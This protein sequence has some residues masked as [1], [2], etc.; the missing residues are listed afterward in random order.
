MLNLK[1]SEKFIRKADF[2]IGA[3]GAYSKVRLAM[4]QMPLFQYSQEYIEHGY[5]ELSIPSKLGDKMIPNHLHIWPR[6]EFMMIAL[7][8]RDMSWTVTLFM[9]FVRFEILDDKEKVMRFFKEM[10]PDAVELIGENEIA[11]TFL[12]TK[13]SHLVSIRCSSYHA[14]S[15][16]LIIGDAAHAMVPFFGQGMNS[17]FEDCSILDSLLTKNRNNIEKTIREFSRHRVDDGHA[18]CDLAMYNYIEMRDLVNK[19]SYRLR[20][21]VDT[22]LF[23][24][25]PTMWIPLYTAVS[26]S[27]MDYNQCRLNRKWQ[28]NVMQF[29]FIAFGIIVSATLYLV[30][31]RFW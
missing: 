28:D 17:G 1:T 9:P 18:I 3:D 25:F 2:I 26:F 29:I 5:L 7:P 23:N 6:G 4:Q 24:F 20:K 27:H 21:K 11:E 22:F 16:F 10:F 30:T 12:T 15:K 19:I 13:P 31:K 8:N 14:G